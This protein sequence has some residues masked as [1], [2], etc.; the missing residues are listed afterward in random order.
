LH[1]RARVKAESIAK[2]VAETD[3]SKTPLGPRETWPQSL[4]TAL[5]ICV[6][7]RF[8][9]VIWWGPELRMLYNDAYA[10]L[11][12]NKHPALGERASDVWSE[13]WGIL[14]PMLRGAFDRGEPSAVEDQP[15]LI[16]RHGYE[17]EAFFTW[18]HTPISGENGVVGVFTTVAET[19]ERVLVERRM[20]AGA[21]HTAPTCAANFSC[22][23]IVVT[24]S[25]PE[26]REYV[27]RI[28]AD[29]AWSV[30]LA[31][32]GDAAIALARVHRPDLI[33]S[34]IDGF[35]HKLR[36]D[37]ELAHVPVL[38]LSKQPDEQ[39]EAGDDYLA[40]PFSA[41]ELVARVGNLLELA[42]MRADAVI[43]QNISSQLTAELDLDRLL[44]LI[45]DE[46]TKLIGAEFGSFFYNVTNERGQSRMLYTISGVPREAFAEAPMP[47]NAGI[48]AHTFSGRGVV[49]SDDIKL[50]PRYG[51]NAPYHGIPKGHLPVTS[52]LAA[53][54]ISR[55]GDVI[56]GLFFG[57]SQP[58][59]FSERHE[60]M[61]VGVA[62]QGAIAIDNARLYERVNELL[63]RERD[64][65]A[66][67]ETASRAKDEFMAI[68]GHELRNPLAP[69]L[70][71]LQLMELRA[72]PQSRERQVIQR[73]VDHL[74]RLVDDLLDVSRITRGK[75]ELSKHRTELAPIVTQAIE[76]ASPL[77]EQKQ[78]RLHVDV[79]R[80]GLEIDADP[81]RMAQVLSNLLTNAA[82]YTPANGDVA[83][84]AAR[85]GG[86]I[87]VRV[88]DTGIGIAAETLARIFEPFVQASQA[89]D[90]S[91]GGL[92]LG[93]AIVKNLVDMHGGQ[94]SAAS[95]GLN[96]GS[97]FV[98]RLPAVGVVAAT[99]GHG[100]SPEHP[101][102]A[103]AHTVLVVD[104]NV[105]AA[106]MVVESL[107]M[108]GHEALAT[109]DGPS[110][111]GVA[112]SMRPDIALLD[113]GL[114]VMDGYE[115]ARRLRDMPE[116][117]GVK[118][119][120]VTGYGQ[121]SDR[122]R[123]LAAGFDEHLVK[124]LRLEKL[125]EILAEPR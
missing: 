94:V 117:E 23:H 68:L 104:D 28:L 62:A 11:L 121:E 98:V 119:I 29:N 97:E 47:R 102:R 38:W 18:S 26:M 7:S 19:T 75:L 48:I 118:L 12:G 70:T 30:E 53:P 51:H 37:S 60:R 9:M 73:Q 78:H 77:I 72:D 125:E 27:A 16:N 106:Q 64:A 10:P 57:H 34:G 105:D 89:L 3:F 43:I 35:L 107:H 111:L 108:L 92:G 95:A 112:P 74:V 83:I 79:P 124:P 49:R 86:E 91:R 56:G 81:A 84:S 22:G 24:D 36:R 67:A 90:R 1:L 88:V 33:V 76:M 55:T 25:D 109:Y 93:L 14:E 5:S 45:T 123:S 100:E 58:A 59:R 69:I 120:A 99:N 65:R 50:D 4:R 103:N 61:L 87:V 54:V 8:P 17:E 15:F 114:P 110:A 6:Q 113:I 21:Q 96:R 2:L 85:E 39:E 41:R 101:P 52:Y 122:Q 82:K 32:D 80:T 44:Q 31:S 115:L 116:L 42:A 20:S 40:Q 66:V 71:A 46:A 13:A 63:E